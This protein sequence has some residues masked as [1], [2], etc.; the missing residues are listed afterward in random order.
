M[1]PLSD[2]G[3]S[4]ACTCFILPT[5]I[6]YF[7]LLSS[8]TRQPIQTLKEARDAVQ[9]LH[10][11]PTTI[12][13]GSVDGEIRTY[14]LRKGQL[15]SDFIGRMFSLSSMMLFLNNIFQSL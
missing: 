14:D 12:T 9:T 6:S 7:S 8:Q 10:L 4:G 13:T 15:S 1:M 5:E 2:C 11:G 3:T